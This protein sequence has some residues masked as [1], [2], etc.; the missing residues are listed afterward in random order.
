MDDLIGAHM[1]AAWS[2]GR[3]ALRDPG[4]DGGGR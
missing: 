3:S 2:E 1:D 4:A